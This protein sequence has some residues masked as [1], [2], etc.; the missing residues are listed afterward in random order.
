MTQTVFLCRSVRGKSELRILQLRHRNPLLGSLHRPAAP[1]RR[2][3]HLLQT[4]RPL[5]PAHSS[6]YEITDSKDLQRKFAAGL[7]LHEGKPASAPSLVGFDQLPLSLADA[8]CN[9]RAE[10]IV[11]TAVLQR[12]PTRRAFLVIPPRN[13]TWLWDL[14]T[15]NTPGGEARLL[16]P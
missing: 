11:L 7:L 12:C 3:P 4:E 1:T 10:P 16:G 13:R 5:L 9:F 8:L 6:C 14:S 15:G 2:P